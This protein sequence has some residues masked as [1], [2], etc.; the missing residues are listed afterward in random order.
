V[1]VDEEAGM[2][3]NFFVSL[4]IVILL[5]VFIGVCLNVNYLRFI[6]PLAIV[7]VP[8][9]GTLYACAVTGFRDSIG[10]VKT[11]FARSAGEGELKRALHFF[12]T[13]E[14]TYIVLGVL[15][16]IME[17]L[18]ML[19]TLEDISQLSGR[20][21]SASVHTFLAFLL[22]AAFVLPCKGVIGKR[23]TALTTAPVTEV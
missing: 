22:I 20:Y 3:R 4:V 19:R 15:G 8:V 17:I 16:T 6:N 9:L 11:A 14:S 12:N 18:D 7:V 2:T 10:A 23:I 13:L 5:M 21:A 1:G